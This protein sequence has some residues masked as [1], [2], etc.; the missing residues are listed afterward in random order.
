[1]ADVDNDGRLEIIVPLQQPAGLYILNSEDLSTLWSAPGTYSG[2]AGYFTNPLGGRVDSSPVIGD[3]DDD[4]YKDIFVGVMAYEEQPE[5]GSIRHLEFDSAQ[6]VI[7]E[8][9][10]R[11]VWHPCAGGFSLGDTDNDGAYELYMADRSI[12]NV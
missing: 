3:I 1:M 4:G 5:T 9:N 10:V 11:I 12:G 7:V 6:G 8:R 2:E